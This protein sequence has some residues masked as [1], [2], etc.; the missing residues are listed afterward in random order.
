MT[1]SKVVT[2]DKY[3]V[4]GNYLLPSTRDFHLFSGLE[5]L[6]FLSNLFSSPHSVGCLPRNLVG[7]LTSISTVVLLGRCSGVRLKNCIVQTDS[8]KALKTGLFRFSL[9]SLYCNFSSKLNLV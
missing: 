4:V 2:L 5:E 3:V 9:L 6:T 8:S 1:Y 7:F